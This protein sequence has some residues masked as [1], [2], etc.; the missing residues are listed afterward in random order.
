M[1][2]FWIKTLARSHFVGGRWVMDNVHEIRCHNK[3]VIN[4]VI[5]EIY[6]DLVLS[7]N[8]F[9]EYVD[10]TK[11]LKL[12]PIYSDQDHYMK[13]F[14]ILVRNLQ[15]RLERS[16]AKMEAILE[17]T[18]AFQQRREVLHIFEARMDALGGLTWHMDRH[19]VVTREMMIKQLLHDLC[20]TAFE[21]TS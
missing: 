9:N 6:Q 8:T 11:R 1:D 18:Q 21:I 4:G 10:D 19:A 17:S 2:L 13:G 3:T 5:N 14:V 20:S 12:F 15:L 7:V 16:G